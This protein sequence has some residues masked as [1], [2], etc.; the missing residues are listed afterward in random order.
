MGMYP[1]ANGFSQ[2]ISSPQRFARVEITN[3]EYEVRELT[4]A[5]SSPWIRPDLYQTTQAIY[6]EKSF[7]GH[8]RTLVVLNLKRIAKAIPGVRGI[9]RRLYN[10]RKRRQAK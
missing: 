3:L 9:A 10:Q 1:Q 6:G 8:L 4:K 5:I 2:R 7:R